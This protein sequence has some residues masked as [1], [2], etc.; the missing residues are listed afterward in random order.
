MKQAS[1]IKFGVEIEC[2]VPSGAMTRGTSHLGEGL[3]IT[4]APTGWG[5][6]RDGSL[7]TAGHSGMEAIEVVSPIL[8]GEDG[9]A[10]AFY[11]AET[12][13]NMGG[14]VNKSCGLHIHV[15]AHG[16]THE[17]IQAVRSTFIRYERAFYAI[18]GG[19]AK[20]RM[21]NPYAKASDNWGSDRSDRYRSLNLTNILGTG[22]GYETIEFRVW[23]STLDPEIITTAIYACVALVC[24]VLNG[25]VQTG[26]RI[27]NFT[28]SVREFCSFAYNETVTRIVPDCTCAEVARLMKDQASKAD[29]AASR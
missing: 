18:C 5:S 27:E 17:Q 13:A 16:M 9:L 22:H 20:E 14:K 3:Q 23:Y 28:E 15:D 29:R 4:W 1:E 10:A 19:K 2:L 12:I 25:N 21:Q 24:Q 6:K 7:T 26:P 8:A 11:V